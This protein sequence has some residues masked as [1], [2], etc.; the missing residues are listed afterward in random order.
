MNNFIEIHKSKLDHLIERFDSSF[1]CYDLDALG[2]HLKFLQDSVPEGVKLWYATKANPLSSVLKEFRRNSFGIDVSAQGEMNHA[3]NAGFEPQNML[4]TGPSKSKKYLQSLVDNKIQT[5]VL[6]SVNQANWLNEIALTQNKKVDVLLRV[7]LPWSEGKSVLGGD[8]ISAF[9]IEPNSWINSNIKELQNLN[10]IGFHCFQW[11]NIL[12]ANRLG[13]IWDKIASSLT[14]LSNDLNIDMKVLDLGGGLGLDYESHQTPLDF[15]EVS[16]QLKKVKEKYS[17]PE[18]WMELGRYAVGNF[19]V[20]CT[21]VIDR[22]NVRGKELLITDGGINHLVRPAIT[23]QSF[24]CQVLKATTNEVN[25]FQVHG[26][27]CT[28][29]DKLGSFELPSNTSPGDWLVFSKTMAYGFT[30]SMPFFLCHNLPAETIIKDGQLEVLRGIETAA[31][32]L[33]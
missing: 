14:Q 33:V 24:P 1:Y 31:S 19:G 5:V 15:T 21:Q 30:E 23:D 6:E 13:L 29:L 28:A 11:G 12:D 18:I 20:Y 10:V 2:E 16:G 25:S 27:L 9:G 32:W 22:K 7:Q 26:P 17:I 3:L 8:E 4:S